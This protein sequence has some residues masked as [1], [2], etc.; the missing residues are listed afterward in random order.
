MQL[1]QSWYLPHAH[2]LFQ[3]CITLDSQADQDLDQQRHSAGSSAKIG[4]LKCQRR[5]AA[6]LE[7]ARVECAGW[8]CTLGC[9]SG[10]SIVRKEE[11][12]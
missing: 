1:F 5:R 2:G 10:C 11:S 3:H 8:L 12:K 7:E 6:Q 4:L 9:E